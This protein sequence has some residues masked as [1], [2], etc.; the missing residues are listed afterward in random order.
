M[1]FYGI[2]LATATLA[3]YGLSGVLASKLGYQA[4]FLLGAVLLAIGA[5]LSLILPAREKKGH[6]GDKVSSVGSWVKVK[7]LLHR[8]GLIVAYCSIFAQYF[9]F[10]GVVTLLPLYV[11]SLGMEVFHV[12]ML[13]ATFAIMFI[14]LQFPVGA[15]SDRIG[16]LRPTIFG[17]SLSIVALIIM[18]VV[19]VFPLLA[20]AMVLYGAAYGVL[21]PSISA[22]L[23]DCTVSEERGLATGIFHALLTTG[24]AVG[25]P[26]MGWV[27]GMVGVKL[28]LILSA[29]VTVLALIVALISVRRV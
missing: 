9:T 7:D 20:A 5:T 6:A 14:I 24:V 21:F 10:G 3:G 16:R 8:R 11:K 25:A 23:V 13:L 19:V 29:S 27:G 4:I 1:A 22:L 15:L 2:S 12:G 17:L 28:G 26:L 18:P